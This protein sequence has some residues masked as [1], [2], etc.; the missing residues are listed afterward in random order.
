MKSV[1]GV[2]NASNGES[3]EIQ[4]D[5]QKSA[6]DDEDNDNEESI[7]PLVVDLAPTRAA[8]PV[9]KAA[10]SIPM[11]RTAAVPLSIGRPTNNA[12]SN[13]SRPKVSKGVNN[14]CIGFGGS[15]VKASPV[16]TSRGSNADGA[17]RSPV[18]GGREAGR[19]EWTA[20]GPTGTVEGRTRGNFR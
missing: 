7:F 6:G 4:F 20:A 19:L 15:D 11:A 14:W 10:Q 17:I 13:P 16:S 9:G 5:R 1:E 8:T 2:T 18:L 12:I 3:D